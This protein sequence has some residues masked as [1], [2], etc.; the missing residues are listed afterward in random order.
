MSLSGL[1]AE[2]YVAVAPDPLLPRI[3]QCRRLRPAP[4]AIGLMQRLDTDKVVVDLQSVINPPQDPDLC[5]RDRIAYRSV[6]G[7]D[8]LRVREFP[9]TSRR[10]CVLW[11]E[12]RSEDRQAPLNA[13]RHLQAPTC[14]FWREGLL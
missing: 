7:Y 13:C 1:A 6:W 10:Q 8:R 2:G 14:V 11:W 12:H 4:R 5:Y 3:P 9:P